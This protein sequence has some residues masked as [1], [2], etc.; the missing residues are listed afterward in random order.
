MCDFVQSGTSD[1]LIYDEVWISFW[2][3]WE[4]LVGKHLIYLSPVE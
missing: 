4:G 1:G 2:K 3:L